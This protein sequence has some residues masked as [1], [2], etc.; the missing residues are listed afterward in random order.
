MYV[1]DFESKRVTSRL[2]GHGDDVNAVCYLDD[3]SPHLIASGSDDS[4]IKAR[5]PDAQGHDNK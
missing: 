2:L 3:S 5:G 1:Y 4:Q